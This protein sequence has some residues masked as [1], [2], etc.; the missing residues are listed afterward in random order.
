MKLPSFILFFLVLTSFAQAQSLPPQDYFKD[1]LRIPLYLAGNFGELRSNHFH[2]GLDLKT[3]GQSGF[4]VLSSA[5][6]YVSQIKVAVFGYGN[7]LFVKHPNGYTTVYGHL[8]E[9]SPKIQSYLRD[10]QY[11]LEKNT[12]DLFPKKDDLPVRAGEVIAISGA[13]GGVEGPHVHFEIRDSTLNPLNPLRFGFD[14]KDNRPPT[15]EKLFVYPQ[16]QKAHA[17]KSVQRQQLHLVKQPDGSFKTNPIQAHGTLGFGISALDYMDG[18]PNTNGMYKIETRL[19]AEP[20]L[21]I[22]FNRFSLSKSRYLNRFIDYAYLKKHKGHIQKLFI[23]ENNEMDVQIEETNKG[24]VRIKDSLDYNYEISLKDFAGNETLIKVP[25]EGR[26]AP[27]NTIEQKEEKNFE[28][29]AFANK[30]NVF[31]LPNHDIFIPKNALY[32]DVYLNLED[33]PDKVTVHEDNIPLHKNITIGFDISKY[34]KEDR[35]KLYVARTFNNGKT[36]YYSK[37]IKDGK[38]MTTK[39]Q[40]FGTYAVAKDTKPPTVE[41]INF[42]SGQWISNADFLKLRIKDQ[43]SGI[44]SYRGTINGEF[45]VLEYDYKTGI[46]KYDFRDKTFEDSKHNLKVI[47]VDNVGNSTT[48]ESTFHRKE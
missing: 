15:I 25:I 11:K 37:T 31:N 35:E 20:Q 2:S 16:G 26:K 46:I 48:Y 29:Q 22:T 33:Y 43:E 27:K 3:Q 8:Q 39:T 9:F 38:R 40:A 17:N 18:S 13:S 41:P 21:K 14:I 28:H 47:V 24:F 30:P 6:G 44:S 7:A 23:E 32:E 10:Q 42:S 19:N 5:E 45:I 36:K 4:D 12:V 34:S 1:P